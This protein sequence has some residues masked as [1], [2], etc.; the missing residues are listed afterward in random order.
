MN[1]QDM[2]EKLKMDPSELYLEETFTDQKIGTIRR[3]TPVDADGNR[4]ASREVR[5]AGQTQVM[6]P[7]GA[8]PISFEL[9]GKDLAECAEQFAGEAEKALQETMEQLRKMQQEQE[10]R[11]QVPGQGGPGGGMPGGGGGMPGGGLKL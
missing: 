1:Q 2:G 7:A 10:S 6:T 4:D 9:N 11:I 8:L 3:L 5:F